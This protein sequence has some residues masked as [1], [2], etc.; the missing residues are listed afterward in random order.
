[1]KGWLWALEIME[2]WFWWLQWLLKAPSS[3]VDICSKWSIYLYM[4]LPQI[5][6]GVQ[7]G[8]VRQGGVKR[9]RWQQWRVPFTPQKSWRHSWTPLRL[10]RRWESH[11]ISPKQDIAQT[12]LTRPRWSERELWAGDLSFTLSHF[13]F[14][15]FKQRQKYS[16]PLLLEADKKCLRDP[17]SFLSCCVSFTILTL[18]VLWQRLT[19]AK[20]YDQKPPINFSLVC[21]I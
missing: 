9:I 6:H 14:T 15:Q 21:S 8:T 10:K 19:W 13:Q 4:Q 5:M 3:S 11:F 18:E 2:L 1:M 17:W 7:K 12:R 20:H 16:H